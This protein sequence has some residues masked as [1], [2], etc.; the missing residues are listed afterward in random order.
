[1]TKVSEEFVPC[2]MLGYLAYSLERG[3]DA[4]TFSWFVSGQT[5]MEL[6]PA[7]Y[8]DVM[9]DQAAQNMAAQNM[10]AQNMAAQNM[11]AQNMAA[12][13]AQLQ[14]DQQYM[15]QAAREVQAVQNRVAAAQ[16]AA[17]VQKA[18]AQV[19]S[20]RCSMSS[21]QSPYMQGGL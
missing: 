3:C 16:N 12:Q 20:V 6:Q 15:R 1:M 4:V 14:Q 9:M 19:R 2:S 10:A 11:A 17:A 8:H 7:V 13:I 5:A 18:A 21:L